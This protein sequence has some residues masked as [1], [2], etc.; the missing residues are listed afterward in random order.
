MS[1]DKIKE[2]MRMIEENNFTIDEVYNNL[3]SD[4]LNTLASMSP[5]KRQDMLKNVNKSDVHSEKIR[6]LAQNHFGTA[7]RYGVDQPSVALKREHEVIIMSIYAVLKKNNMLP[8]EIDKQTL[9]PVRAYVVKFAATTNLSQDE[10]Q[11]PQ[12]TYGT[13]NKPQYTTTPTTSGITYNINE[14]SGGGDYVLA[15]SDSGQVELIFDDENQDHLLQMNMYISNTV[16]KRTIVT[17]VEEIKHIGGIKAIT[18][19]KTRL[20]VIRF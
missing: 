6:S 15:T 14:V 8:S 11:Q 4:Q 7:S 13:V 18:T 2:R 3:T 1:I 16:D 20:I 5:N 12:S 10:P 17:T 19:P 9:K